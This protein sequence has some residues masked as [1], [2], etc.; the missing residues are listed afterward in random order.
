[1][2]R[3]VQHLL[4]GQDV[5]PAGRPRVPDATRRIRRY[6]RQLEAAQAQL[7][8]RESE[9]RAQK[10]LDI[11]RSLR[12]LVGLVFYGTA[13]GGTAQCL[14]LAFGAEA[15]GKSTVA[16]R[17]GELCESAEKLFREYFAG[18][19]TCAACDEIYLSGHPVLEAV[20]PVSLAI[21]ALRA[22]VAPTQAQ[23]EEV[24]ADFSDLEAAVSD[25]GLGVSKALAATVARSGLDLWHLLRHCAAAVGRLE[26]RAYERIT[27]VDEKAAQYIAML[28]YPPGRTAPPQLARLEQAQE[29]CARA[30]H[31][32]DDACTVLGW[33]YEA[34]HPLDAQGRV[35]T[36]AQMRGDW[37]AALDLI[38]YLEAEELWALEKK[39]RGKVT[40]ACAQGLEERLRR[41]PLPRG[42]RAAERE[43]LQRVVCQAWTFHHRQQTHILHAPRAAAVTAAAHVGLP[44]SAAHL[45][46]YCQ[47]VFDLL[48]R[49]LIA[50]SA[51]ECVNSLTRLREGAKRHPHPKFMYLLAWLHNTRAFTEG[52]RKG[53][54]PAELLGVVLPKDGWEMLLDRVQAHRPKTRPHA[55]SAIQ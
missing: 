40:G 49:T 51:V 42:W 27:D 12:L 37:E 8:A 34:A 1:V 41:V 5:R 6:R 46:E 3:R 23:W 36:P 33:L 18:R 44:S 45:Q 22:D 52:K 2:S 43:E 28:P 9:L 24:L 29:K 26:Q 55:V 13:L 54:T 17:V 31:T 47:A 50:S 4:A 11:T 53:L 38:D 32:Y 39:L 25:Q 15:P 48:E 21:T 10:Q 20:E 19:G 16:W 30:I 14:A 35:R 7:A